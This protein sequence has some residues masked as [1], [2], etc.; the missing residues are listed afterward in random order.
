MLDGGR[1][2]SGRFGSRRRAVTPFPTPVRL[3]T[4]WY[5]L[6]NFRTLDLP[7]SGDGCASGQRER[8]PID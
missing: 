7:L 6:W 5:A 8:A 3:A 1:R 2:I 4:D